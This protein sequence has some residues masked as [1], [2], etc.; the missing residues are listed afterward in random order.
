[1]KIASNANMNIEKEI[2]YTYQCIAR[3]FA[4]LGENDKAIVY[5]WDSIRNLSTE[6]LDTKKNFYC[7][8]SSHC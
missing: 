5:Y 4:E 2:G 7:R 8:Y 3:T 1:M 6:I